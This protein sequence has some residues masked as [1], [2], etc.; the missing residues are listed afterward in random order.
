MS[1]QNILLPQPAGERM[2]G[3]QVGQALLSSPDDRFARE[4]TIERWID[5]GHLPPFMANLARFEV[6]VPNDVRNLIFFVMPEVLC[7]GTDEDY[8]RVPLFPTTAQ[9]IADKLG[10]ILP[11]TKISDLVWRYAD[12]KATP[13]PWGPPYDASMMNSYRIVEHNRRCNL[14]VRRAKPNY[15]PGM[16]VTGLKKDV[17]VCH[18]MKHN[19]EHVWIYGWHKSNGEPT[20]GL[21]GGH[22]LQYC[23]YSHSVRLILRWGILREP[24]G[25]E[26]TID[27][28]DVLANPK[29]YKAIC[30]PAPLTSWR[31]SA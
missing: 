26:T 23:D 29:L 22:E 5:E 27:L 16:V 24:T 28:V 18:E 11:T 21:Y 25:L 19:S 9:R 12:V 13:E 8:I 2:T 31:Y 6:P 1:Q 20:Q 15:T 10:C 3:L 4:L 14:A 17:V 7:L 30:S